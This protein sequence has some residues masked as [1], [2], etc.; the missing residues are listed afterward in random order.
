VHKK[1]VDSFSNG[2]EVIS[3]CCDKYSFAKEV[4]DEARGHQ[5]MSILGLGYVFRVCPYVDY[6]FIQ[7]RKADMQCTIFSPKVPS[8]LRTIA[9]LAEDMEHSKL[10][11]YGWLVIQNSQFSTL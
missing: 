4:K 3:A 10:V 8:G 11:L 6:C 9:G 5:R 1:N 7:H 2:I